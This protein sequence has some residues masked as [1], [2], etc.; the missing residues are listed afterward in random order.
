MVRRSNQQ[1]NDDCRTGMVVH[2]LIAASEP[3]LR[4][5]ASSVSVP[6]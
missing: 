5:A 6:Q 4:G 2:L 3:P 1:M